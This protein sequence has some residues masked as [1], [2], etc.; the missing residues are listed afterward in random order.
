MDNPG[1]EDTARKSSSTEA[2]SSATRV[3]RRLDAAH[4]QG[5]FRPHSLGDKSLKAAT[6]VYF[7]ALTFL[8]LTRDPFRVARVYPVSHSLLVQ[9]KPYAHFLSFTLLAVL[10]FS[11][12]WPVRRRT[13]LAILLGYA[14]A[15]ECVQWFVGR[16]PEFTDFFQD[17]IGILAG[18]TICWG[19]FRARAWFAR[20]VNA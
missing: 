3:S 8:L 15:S 9:L 6:L 13:V 4:H 1:G 12:S 19:F 20:Y 16:S 17:A 18:A 11:V 2:G 10:A 14:A 5:L 7:A